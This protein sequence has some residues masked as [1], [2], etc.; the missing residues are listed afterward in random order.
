MR[1]E[2]TAAEVSGDDR[3]DSVRGTRRKRFSATVRSARRADS[4][5]ERTAVCRPDELVAPR[6]ADCPGPD[7]PTRG[8][9]P[10]GFERVSRVEDVG[11][12]NPRIVGL[13]ASVAAP[14]QSL[15]DVSVRTGTDGVLVSLAASSVVAERLSATTGT[16]GRRLSVRNVRARSI[17]VISTMPESSSGRGGSRR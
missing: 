11:Q 13:R 15:V 2:P 1:V 9:S 6:L 3:P 5:P 12:V 4:A 10:R 17:R 7:A 8:A 16:L 14:G